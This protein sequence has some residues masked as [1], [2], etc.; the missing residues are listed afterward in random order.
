MTLFTRGSNVHALLRVGPGLRAY[1]GWDTRREGL[2][3]RP[4]RRPRKRLGG[5]HGRTTEAA[6]SAQ[7]PSSE[8][9]CTEDGPEGS[10]REVEGRGPQHEEQARQAPSEAASEEASSHGAACGRSLRKHR[11]QAMQPER[12]RSDVLKRGGLRTPNCG[13]SSVV[14][15]HLAKVDVV[16]SSPI[17]RSGASRRPRRSS[18][19]LGSGVPD[20]GFA[21]WPPS[22]PSAASSRGRD[23]G[24]KRSKRRRGSQEERQ[25]SAKP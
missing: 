12:A 23:G 18:V 9:D 6:R 24:R 21:S 19:P 13:R 1:L 15:C 7:A 5:R 16:G 22:E 3:E 2:S 20:L 25:R 4:L 17:A 14:E 10:L 11:M 8:E